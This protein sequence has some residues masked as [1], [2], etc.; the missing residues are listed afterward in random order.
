MSDTA[1]P[2]LVLDA[3]AARA[4]FAAPPYD[5]LLAKGAPALV[6]AGETGAVLWGNG[7]ARALF[8][9]A[10]GAIALNPAL[11]TFIMSMGAGA[12]RL[13]RIRMY[14]RAVDGPVTFLCQRH[15][16]GK[17]MSPARPSSGW[18]CGCARGAA[19]P[20]PCS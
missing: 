16:D 10:G 6:V 8:G 19:R 4:L 2:S 7:G 11:A 1:S 18:T 14:G 9:A 20:R 13:A 12:P 15:A 17:G 3:K 5:A